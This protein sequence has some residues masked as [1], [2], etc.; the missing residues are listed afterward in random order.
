MDSF[1]WTDLD[2]VATTIA[3]LRINMDAAVFSEEE[4]GA[5]ESA[6]AG[7]AAFTLGLINGIEPD[8]FLCL[9]FAGELKEDAG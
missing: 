8:G 2:A 7:F 4:R 6:D 9:A 3:L 5:S 1:E